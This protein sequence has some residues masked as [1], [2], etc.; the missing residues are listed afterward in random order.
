MCWRR[1][2]LSLLLLLLRHAHRT[3]D[4]RR[5]DRWGR[6][7]DHR[8][9]DFRSVYRNRNNRLDHH[10]WFLLIVPEKETVEVLLAHHAMLEVKKYW[11][12]IVLGWGTAW[13][14]QVLLSRAPLRVHVNQADGWQT[15]S[16]RNRL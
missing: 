8:A 14:L 5:N 16:R 9:D 4:H 12:L 7:H 1:R 2:R 3:G 6:W 11:G 15:L 10:D 13:D